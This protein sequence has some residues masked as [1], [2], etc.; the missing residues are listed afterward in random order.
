MHAW[1][2]DSPNDAQETTNANQQIDDFVFLNRTTNSAVHRP[3]SLAG[4]V[5][6][7]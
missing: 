3:P 1:Q 2:R 5:S 7:A 6:L 4:Q